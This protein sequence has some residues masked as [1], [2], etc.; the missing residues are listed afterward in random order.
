MTSG[1]GGSGCFSGVGIFFAWGLVSTFLTSADGLE[2]DER[3]SLFLHWQKAPT[4]T[5]SQSL[6]KKF[7]CKFP[8]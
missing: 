1:L 3:G 2:A 5:R 6:E 8:Y 7:I 4:I